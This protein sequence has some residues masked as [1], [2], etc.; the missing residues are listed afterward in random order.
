MVIKYAAVEGWV[1]PDAV[2]VV[3]SHLSPCTQANA[4]STFNILNQEGRKVAAAL[5][6]CG[7]S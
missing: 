6:P 3:V 4:I 5:L 1:G 2:T 7:A